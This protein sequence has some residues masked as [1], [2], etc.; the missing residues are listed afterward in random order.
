MDFLPV[1]PEIVNQRRNDPLRVLKRL[2]GLRLFNLPPQVLFFRMV[3]G[4]EL[5]AGPVPAPALLAPHQNSA[6]LSANAF[7]K[8]DNAGIER[9]IGLDPQ[10]GCAEVNDLGAVIVPFEIV[11][12]DNPEGTVTLHGYGVPPQSFPVLVSYLIH[13]VKCRFAKG[14]SV[15]LPRWCAGSTAWHECM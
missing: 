12:R 5:D 4:H 2:A 13:N 10:A 9:L 11:K 6:L 1:F 3:K 15:V 14:R 8:P 7:L